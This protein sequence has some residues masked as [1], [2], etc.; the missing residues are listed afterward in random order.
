M[1]STGDHLELTVAPDEATLNTHLHIVQGP[2]ICSDGVG[3][4]SK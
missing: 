1:T 2:D 3:L 4:L